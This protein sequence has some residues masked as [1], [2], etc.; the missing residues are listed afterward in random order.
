MGRDH[1]LLRSLPGTDAGHE[2][3]NTQGTDLKAWLTLDSL[4]TY[5]VDGITGCGI[6]VTRPVWAI[7]DETDQNQVI[8]GYRVGWFN[9][10]QPGDNIKAGKKLLDHPDADRIDREIQRYFIPDLDMS[11]DRWTRFQ[12]VTALLHTTG[13]RHYNYRDLTMEIE[14]HPQEW[15]DLARRAGSFFDVSSASWAQKTFDPEIPF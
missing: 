13:T 1:L 2:T 7:S 8:H 14:L 11:L 9:Q 12:M 3:L 6:W 15:F 10:I 4:W 5:A